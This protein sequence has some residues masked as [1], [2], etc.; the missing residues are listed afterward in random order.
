MK[1]ILKIAGGGILAA[2]AGVC[3]AKAVS[4]PDITEYEIYSKKLPEKFDGFKIAHISDFHCAC[5]P[6]LVP[7]IKSINADIIVSTGDMVNKNNSIERAVNLTRKLTDIAPLYMVSGN[8]DKERVEHMEIED[9]CNGG[10][11]RFLHNESVLI[12]RGGESIQLSGTDDPYAGARDDYVQRAMN[13]KLDM[14][15][16]YSGFHILLFHRA[17]L[18]DIPAQR[19]FDLMLAGHMHGGQIRIPKIGGILPPKSNI[20]NGFFPKYTGG[21]Y[22]I[23]N[24]TLIVNRGLG[25]PIPI[26]RINNHPEIVVIKLN[27]MK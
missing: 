8:H 26:P 2:A 11:G 6:E 3:A 18:A 16:P 5:I 19:G 23:G 1:K 9:I 15:R 24:S 10:E 14:L 20:D 22:I 4:G 17:N 27:H 7:V 13:E 12:E 21:K 25:N